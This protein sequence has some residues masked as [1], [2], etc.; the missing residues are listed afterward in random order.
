MI[1]LIPELTVSDVDKAKKL[2]IDML[3]F[4]RI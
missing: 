2:Y 3:G 4:I 1:V